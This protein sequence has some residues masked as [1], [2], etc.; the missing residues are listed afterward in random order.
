[1]LSSRPPVV[2]KLLRSFLILRVHLS[3]DRWT[4]LGLTIR[5]S[6]CLCFALSS[7][8]DYYTLPLPFCQAFFRFYFSTRFSS[9]FSISHLTFFIRSLPFS[10]VFALQYFLYFVGYLLVDTTLRGSQALYYARIASGNTAEHPIRPVR[11]SELP[12]FPRRRGLHIP[13]SRASARAHSF[14]RS[15]SP[16]R[17]TLGSP[18]RL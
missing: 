14:R 11:R 9:V 15:S 6:R 1:M 18:V 10:I 13:R 7:E 17:A 12:P 2:S 4:V 3:L 8:L 16:L 5:F